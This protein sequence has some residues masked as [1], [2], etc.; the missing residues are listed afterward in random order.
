MA[1]ALPLKENNSD[2]LSLREIANEVKFY[3][4]TKVNPDIPQEL[5]LN[6]KNSVDNSNYN[7]MH[8]TK[9]EL[10]VSSLNFTLPY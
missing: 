10:F 4:Y 1:C 9:Y 7:S 3:L 5:L 2:L 6:N 8:Q